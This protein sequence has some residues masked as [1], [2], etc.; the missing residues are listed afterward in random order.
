M[1][2][3]V[4]DNSCNALEIH[5]RK[6]RAGSDALCTFLPF[7]MKAEKEA[8]SRG[9]AGLQIDEETPMP[10]PVHCI[11]DSEMRVYLQNQF[12]VFQ[13]SV[14]I[15]THRAYESKLH[16]YA[17]HL[18]VC[19]CQ[20]LSSRPYKPVRLKT[21]ESHHRYHCADS[22]GYTQYKGAKGSFYARHRGVF[23]V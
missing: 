22:M 13:T 20:A 7:Q 11:K 10:K 17:A 15:N 16:K 18:A 4:M 2:A 23:M 8:A 6:R 19:A 1:A 9:L 14:Q 21:R 12:Q 5:I 3:T